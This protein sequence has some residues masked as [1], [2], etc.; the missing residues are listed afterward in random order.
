VAL[1]GT[2]ST[3]V[4][5]VPHLGRDAKHLYVFQRTPSYVDARSNG[6]TDPAWAKS[7][8][9]GWQLERRKNFDAGSFGSFNA[10]EEDI[11]CD[12]WSEIARNLSAKRIALGNPTLTP[13]EIGDLR[14]V[15]DY[16]AMERLRRRIE[17]IVTDKKTA[18]MLK[19]WYRFL[20]KR[21]CFNDDY[22]PTFNRPNVT[23]VDVS[24]S[25]GVERITEKGLVV[26][27]VEY[28]VD[29]IVY[30]SGFEVTTDSKRR[31]GIEVIEGRDGLSL[32][33]HWAT[34]YRTLHGMMSHGFPNQ[35]FTGFTQIG[36][37][38]NI[39]AMYDQQA[40]H[41]AYV[42]K[43]LLARG[44]TTVETTAEAQDAWVKEVRANLNLNAPFWQACTPGY[45]NNE[46]IAVNSSA[47]F[48]EPYYKGYY[49][50]DVLLKEWRDAGD[51]KGLTL[52]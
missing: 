5:C 14:E 9:P 42:I 48:G 11:I 12:G 52:A 24:A 28:E 35:F 15:E 26:G 23:L 51:L 33:D 36:L 44:A 2:G 3:A 30:A 49:A 6:P 16:K 50:F 29:L 8:K 10:P 13:Q 18:E 39:T 45:Y 34:G 27:G 43:E 40:T 25:K 32:Y 22:L 1:I 46:G 4:Q 31:Y 41:I 38:A 20:C 21:P 17:S 19:P 7:L 37:S 47:L